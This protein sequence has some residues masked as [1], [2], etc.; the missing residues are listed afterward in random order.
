MNLEKLKNL[1][2]AWWVTPAVAVIS[3]GIP[4]LMPNMQLTRSI[5]HFLY[6]PERW[7]GAVSFRLHDV[8]GYTGTK[9]IDVVLLTHRF[10][11]NSRVT[12]LR[13]GRPPELVAAGAPAASLVLDEPK[14]RT[15][16]TPLFDL[17]LPPETLV[18][19]S[20][21][22]PRGTPPSRYTVIT[23]QCTKELTRA[24]DLVVLPRNELRKTRITYLLSFVAL[25]LAAVFMPRYAQ[26]A[27]PDDTSDPLQ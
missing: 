12:F 20:V 10:G 19:A 8:P 4:L 15:S 6:P 11:D 21:V 18:A 13:D 16:G 26:L 7:I 23:T 3:F 14:A 27:H 5:A 17:D 1:C 22:A 9:D 25:G 2:T 24:D